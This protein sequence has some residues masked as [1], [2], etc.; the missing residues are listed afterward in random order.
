MM[1]ESLEKITPE[2]QSL[3]A[4][5]MDILCTEYPPKKIN[6]EYMLVAMLDN[7]KCHAYELLNSC[8][9]S[10]SINE[11]REIYSSLLEQNSNSQFYKNQK[12]EMIFDEALEKIINAAQNEK[13]IL[14]S[15]IIGSEHFLLSILN[16]NNKEE[17]F[18]DVFK[19]IGIDYSFLQTKCME[20]NNK[21]KENKLIKPNGILQLK[22][23]INTKNA[24]VKTP[25]I[26]QYTINLNKL[27]K[28]G[29]IDELIGRDKEIEQIIKVLARRNKNNVILVGKSGVGKTQI[30][31]GIAHLINQN[32]VPQLLQNK[33]VVMINIVALISGTHFRGMFEERVNGL[34]EE[35][36]Q[37]KKHILFIDDMQTVLKSSNKEKDT[38]ISSMISTVLSE[39]NV[40]VIGAVNFKDYRNSVENN[41][42]IARKL[43]KIII[44][45]TSIEET[46][47]IIEQNKTY[48]EEHHKVRYS[49]EIIKK[50]VELSD[51]YITERSL[52]DSAFDVIDLSGART[53][54]L[55]RESDEIIEHRKELEK[56]SIEKTD[57]LNNGNF[58][59]IDSIEERERFHKKEI[60]E[61][62]RNDEQ[63]A[64]NKII[65]ITID[66]IL[67]SISEIANVPVDRLQ[68]ND[69]ASIANIDNV[70]KE[71]VIGQDEAIDKICRIIKRNKVGLGNKTKTRGN[72]LL[73]GKSGVGKCVC[74]ETIIRIRNKQT[75]EIQELTISEF[76]NLIKK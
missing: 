20:K 59:F 22:S 30:V 23:N 40:R 70:L 11:L 2:L 21:N 27:A 14:Q 37:S 55:Q 42:S 38:D 57:A 18:I 28:L 16:P 26:D 45:P 7:S 35:L 47:K 73:I 68:K 58:E 9:T 75:L 41:T 72:L 69:K 65:D 64:E 25:F 32:K 3:F 50:C 19:N 36:K 29:E 6:I 62:K 39:G 17:T 8:L 71:H 61:L 43:Q 12:D 46:I 52:P 67:A 63:N 34:F 56:L 24:N 13:E 51:R 5:I 48:Y 74:G 15:P 66:D 44:E 54:F 10:S 60:A 31:H 4:Y 33:E 76:Y 53:C 49:S 1:K